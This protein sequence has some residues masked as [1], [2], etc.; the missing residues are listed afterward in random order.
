MKKYFMGLGVFLISLLLISTVTAVPQTHSKP[1]M[2]LI[3]SIEDKKNIID[4]KSLNDILNNIES[5]GIIDLLIQ[6]ITLIIQFVMEIIS[7]IQNVISLVNLVQNLIDAFTT[8]FQLIQDLIEI[9]TN[10]F[11]PS[12]I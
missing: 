12:S 1:A 6:L 7:I 5:G 10:I 4:F 8:L 3:N 9:I 11:N 2:N